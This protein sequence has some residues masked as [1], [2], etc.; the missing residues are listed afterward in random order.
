MKGSNLCFNCWRT[1]DH[2]YDV[3]YCSKACREEAKT[4]GHDDDVRSYLAT[5]RKEEKALEARYF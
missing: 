5:L 2:A 3:L 1:F 4:T